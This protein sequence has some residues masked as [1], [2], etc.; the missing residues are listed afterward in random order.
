MRPVARRLDDVE[1][2]RSVC[3]FRQ[4]LLK[5]D[6]GT[7]ASITYLAVYEAEC[8]YHNET[9]EFYYVLEGSG[10]LHLDDETIDLEPN[11]VVWIP[12]GVKHSAEGDVKVLV[13]CVPAFDADDQHLVG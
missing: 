13:I 4:R 9:T 7:P 1:K 6:D 2:E 11:M 12:P 5:K 8:H 3:G 10:K